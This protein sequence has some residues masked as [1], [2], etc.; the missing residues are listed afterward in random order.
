VLFVYREEY[1][2]SRAEP[3]EG[4]PEHLTWQDEMDRT[5]GLAE[6]IVAKQR[7]GPVGTVKMQFTGEFTRFSDYIDPDRVPERTGY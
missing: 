7:H 6:V 2:V 5:M 4:T 3:R 1:Y